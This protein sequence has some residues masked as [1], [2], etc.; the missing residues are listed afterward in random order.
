MNQTQT[1]TFQTLPT[2]VAELQA[3]PEYSLDSPFKTCALALVA[4]MQY[5]AN[6]N[7]CLAMLD[8]LRGPDP[9]SP[10]AKQF[11]RD[12]LTGKQY[13]VSSF[14]AGSSVQNSYKPSVPYTISVSDNPYSYPEANWATL[15]VQSS[16]ADSPR[17]MKFRLKPSTGQWFLNDIQCLSDIRIPAADD[18]WA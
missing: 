5:Q 2:T 6:T 9:M 12:R 11:L 16:G 10:Y 15:Y 7:E 14:F 13:K 3:L 18:P 8:A 4:L 17:P 1:F